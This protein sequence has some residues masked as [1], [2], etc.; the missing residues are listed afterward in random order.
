MRPVESISSND[1]GLFVVEE[2]VPGQIPANPIWTEKEP[3]DYNN[4][5]TDLKTVQRMPINNNRR[6]K[7]GTV[8]GYTAGAGYETDLTAEILRNEAP[9]FFFSNPRTK[10]ELV[11]TATTADGFTV[12]AGGA[13]YVAGTIIAAEG[14]TDPSNNGRFVAGA[15]SDA[16]TVS[17]AGLVAAAGQAIRLTRAGVQF[18]AGDASID[19]S[20]PLP[21]LVTVA[22]DLTTLGLIPG[23]IVYLGG[24]TDASTF[25]ES[26]KGWCR[27]KSVA[28]H[29]LVFDKTDFPFIAAAGGAKTIELYFGTVI[30]DEDAALQ[31]T[32]TYSIMRHAGKPDRDAP[33]A[34][35]AEVITRCVANQLKITVP[36]E[37]KITCSL[38][39]MGADS[40]YYRDV[41][42]E[43][44][45]SQYIG[46]TESD[47]INSTGD[48]KRANMFVYPEAGNVSSA[49]LPIVAVFSAFDLT[50]DNQIK[51]NKAVTRMGTF[52]LSPGNFAVSGSFTG[53]FVTTDAL[54]AMRDNSDATFMMAAFKANKGV[55]LDIPMLS[56]SSKGLDVKINEQVMIPIDAAASTGRKYDTNMSHTALMV[57]FDYLPDV[58]NAAD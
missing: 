51:E 23:E 49:P 7:K 24:D 54:Q 40:K 57:F 22:K 17:V 6:N 38:S 33:N 55:A 42:T 11:A 43:I 36:E 12:A 18:T 15:N 56:L 58:A 10:S 5:G 44:P 14:A 46:I 13:S 50:F 27:V 52:V 32:H 4:F 34:I 37:D 19:V 45:G 35:Q 8:V 29:R 26:A 2:I 1:T 3:N 21:A 31:V 25:G 41:A 28:A 16:D 9:G 47:A 30:R 48:M 20:G 39:F 53:Y